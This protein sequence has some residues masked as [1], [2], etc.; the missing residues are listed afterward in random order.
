[1]RGAVRFTVAALTVAV[2]IAFAEEDERRTDTPLFDYA[3]EQPSPSAPFAGTLNKLVAQHTAEIARNPPPPDGECAQTLGASRFARLYEDLAV[4]LANAGDYDGAISAHEK[5][6]ACTPRAIPVHA[7]LAEELLHAGRYK[8][9]RAAAQRAAAIRR[10]DLSELRPLDSVLMQLDFIDERWAESVARLRAMA[11]SEPDAERATYWQILLWLAQRRAGVREPE[12]AQREG[13]HVHE[14]WP[15]PIL[16]FLKGSLTE[17]Q[18][19]EHIEDVRDDRRRRE[20]LAE[21][22]YYVG[23]ARLAQGETEVARRYFAAAVNLK[24]LYFIEHHLALA[25]VTKMRAAREGDAHALETNESGRDV[26]E[27]PSGDRGGSLE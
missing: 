16:D 7:A 9:A 13:E 12:L 5:A 3:L 15:M 14:G 19:L 27:A 20:L 26:A 17:D 21:A 4:A 23:Q 6:L 24:V 18:L 25:E 11:A 1:M 8:E 2:S 22:L 10:T